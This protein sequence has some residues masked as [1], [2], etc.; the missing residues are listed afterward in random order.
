MVGLYDRQGV[1]RFA[2]STVAACLDYAALF[3][4]PLVQGSLQDLPE[5]IT[6]AVR[7]RGDRR[8]EGRSN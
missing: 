8:L 2:G 5:P 6:S 4:I 3:E 7:I 1:L